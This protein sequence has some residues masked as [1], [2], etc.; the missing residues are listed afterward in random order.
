MSRTEKV[1]RPALAGKKVPILTLD[2]KWYQ[3]FRNVGM[4]AE[5]SQKADELNAL[6][7]RQGKIN[8]E[9]RQIKAIKKKLLDEMVPLSAQNNSDAAAKLQEHKKLIDDCNTKLEGYQDEML[10]LPEQITEVNIDLM[11]LTMDPCYDLLKDNNA[12]IK[13][14]QD[15]IKKMRIELKKDII[16]KQDKEIMNREMYSYMHD[17]FGAEVINLFDMKYIPNEIKPSGS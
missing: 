4:T 2:G 1:Y 7:R 3:L 17:I 6:L 16:K 14:Y 5:I 9:S 15:M 12:D 13:R 10:D 11:L 8:T